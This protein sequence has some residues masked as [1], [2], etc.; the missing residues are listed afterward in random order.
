M[1][2]WPSGWG[3]MPVAYL[4]LADADNNGGL[5]IIGDRPQPADEEDWGKLSMLTNSCKEW[6]PCCLYVHTRGRTLQS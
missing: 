3:P 6:Y 1:T 2:D 4:G 5:T